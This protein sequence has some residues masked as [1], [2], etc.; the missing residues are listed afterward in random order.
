M[1]GVG[2]LTI[3]KLLGHALVETTERYVHLSDRSVAE[4]ADRQM[5]DALQRYQSARD[6]Y[7]AAGG[8]QA[9][10]DDLGSDRIPF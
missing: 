3:A 5:A 2:M 7:D 10:A 9:Q 8:D 6:R 1:N 4:A